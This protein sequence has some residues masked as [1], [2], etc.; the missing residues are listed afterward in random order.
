[1]RILSFN[2]FEYKKGGIWYAKASDIL[3]PDETTQYDYISDEM[4]EKYLLSG[5][6]IDTIDGMH[7]GH[8][9]TPEIHAQRIAS[10]INLIQTGVSL[11]PVTLFCN[12]IDDEIFKVEDI[13][14]GWHRLRAS[15][16]L[17]QPIKFIL[18]FQE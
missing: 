8:N 7:K 1:M 13:D 10:L 12:Y 16:Y 11:Y 18:D 2:K 3:K 14:D 17:N 15:C 6:F 4:I 9:D 5:E